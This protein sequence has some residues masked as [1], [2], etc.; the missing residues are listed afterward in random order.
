MSSL[1]YLSV[2]KNPAV[3][4]AHWGHGKIFS[5][6]MFCYGDG[7]LSNP[8]ISFLLNF[9]AISQLAADQ[10]TTIFGQ[11]NSLL[12]ILLLQMSLDLLGIKCSYYYL[13]S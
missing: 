13:T 5:I 4:L 2:N 7:Q 10:G 8:H 11:R 9:I 3:H 6:I 12:H 1:L